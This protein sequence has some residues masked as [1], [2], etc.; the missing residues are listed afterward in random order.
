MSV[1]KLR[2]LIVDDSAF[3]RLLLNDILA[4]SPDIEIIGSASEG[5]KGANMAIREKPDVVLMD[6]N[7]GEYDGIYAVK[8]I[9]KQRPTPIL[10][11]SAIGNTNLGPIF[12]ALRLGAVDYINKPSKGN[13]KIRQLENELIEKIKQ[14]AKA[15]PKVDLAVIDSPSSKT[16]S[17]APLSKPKKDYRFDIIGIGASTG[18]PAAIEKVVTLFPANLGVP[19]II[20]Q[21]MPGNFIHPFVNRLNSLTKLKVMVGKAGM[22][23]SAGDIVVAPG[24]TNMVLKKDKATGK[25]VI[26]FNDQVYADY[27]NPSINAMMN[28]LA[29][30]YGNRTLAVLLTGMGRDGADGLKQIKDQGG[31]TIAQDKE[32]SVIF[33]MPKVAIERNAVSKVLAINEIGSFLTKK[34]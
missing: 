3:M 23:P 29:A 18:G 16:S 33:G 1:R 17:L 13:S 5:E 11:L 26:A 28:S 7:M 31:Y 14:V 34:L 2:V 19:V 30:I 10:I 12:Q 21:H 24:H 22:V 15:Q 25:G 32:S 6:M 9:M 27:N 8:K 20:C 4:K